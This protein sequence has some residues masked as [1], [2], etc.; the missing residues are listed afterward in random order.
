MLSPAQ[1]IELAVE[2]PASGGRMIARHEGQVVLVLAAIPGERVIARVDR[3]EKRLAFATT[4]RVLEPSPARR[5]GVADPLCGGCVYSHIDYTMQVALKGEVIADA[6][7]RIGRVPLD[8]VPVVEPSPEDG[9]RMRAR[10]HVRDGR[11]GFYREGTHALCDAAATRQLR[12]D[13]FVAVEAALRALADAG[14]SATG[15]EVA[16]NIAADQ[17]ALHLELGPGRPPSAGILDQV[18][19]AAGIVGCT[20]RTPD[21][22]LFST[23][24]P[25]VSDA[26]GVLT[27]GR[28]E[29]GVLRRR[30]ESFF[31]GNRYLLPR[32][33]TSVLDSVPRG[34]EVLDLYAGVGL[35]SVALAATG[36]AHVTAVE[37]D[38]AG[39]EDLQHNAAPFAG[40]LDTVISRVED[41]L[42]RRRSAA[43]TVVVDPP[44]TGMSREA[45]DAI[46][47]HGAAR[48]VYVSCDPPTMARDA[49]RLLDAGYTL[50]SLKGFDL[51]PNTPHVESLGVFERT[52]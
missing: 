10:L 11:A 9:Y 23:A 3:V 6:F 13:T 43:S 4:V 35:F 17:R 5:E 37:G 21:G 25:H 34:G 12:P 45:M 28:A 29:N 7:R 8:T 41:Y 49:R 44:R 39:G 47:R 36:A 16:E 30:P 51:F 15:I 20:A 24:H 27:A 14:M 18:A 31:Q 42:A 40:R 2:K 26:M 32:L 38:R 1:E 19:S 50:S 46:A 52:A 48:I 33:V 22:I